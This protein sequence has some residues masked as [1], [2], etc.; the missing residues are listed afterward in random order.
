MALGVL[1]TTLLWLLVG[2]YIAGVYLDCIA[3]SAE[4][5]CLSASEQALRSSLALLLGLVFTLVCWR[6]IK[7]R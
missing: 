5:P 2:F 3:S 6:I 1:A 4:Y 7:R